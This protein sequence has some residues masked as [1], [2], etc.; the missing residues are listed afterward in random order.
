MSTEPTTPD[1]APGRENARIGTTLTFAGNG[2][3]IW[4]LRLQA[5][6]TLPAHRHDRPY[7]WTVLT[8]GQGRSRYSDGDVID[9]QYTAGETK[10]FKDLTTENGFVHDLTNTGSTELVFV[11]VEFDR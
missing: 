9:H 1:G 4:H 8:D 11:T 7:F 2:M 3:R 5:G 6:E 10:H